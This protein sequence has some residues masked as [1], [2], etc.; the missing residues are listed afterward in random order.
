MARLEW[1]KTSE[2]LY[3][4]GVKNCALYPWD[5]NKN[6]SYSEV[7]LTATTPTSFPTGYYE[8]DATTDPDEF[9]ATEDL[10]YN[11][12][13]AY[14]KF[15][16]EYY[17]EQPTTG[18][19]SR[20]YVEDDGV[21]TQVAAGTE[22][23][24]GNYATI[25]KIDKQLPKWPDGYY[26]N[27]SGDP[28]DSAFSSGSTYYVKVTSGGY[29][30]GVAWNGITAVNETPT[31][32]EATD[33][34][35]D[36]MKYLSLL[37]AEELEGTIEAYMYPDEWEQCDG[38][39]TTQGVTFGQQSRKQFCLAYVT[40]VGNDTDN[41][42]FGEKLHILYNAKA[43]PSE[44]AYA[45]INDS[46]EAITFS[47]SLKATKEKIS[48][49]MKTEFK[50]TFGADLKDV[51]LITISSKTKKGEDTP[52]YEAIYNALYGTDS[53]DPTL[54]TPDQICEIILAQG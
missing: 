42:D 49:A 18:W 23:V 24:A 36:D 31:G 2:R 44:R 3:E 12:G 52:Y 4:T 21:Y 15:T 16:S 28:I 29:G 17:A 22:F 45:T 13:K 5:S 32:A 53:S 25:T 33:L 9:V 30:T 6:V 26:K 27:S 47:W 50:N 10:A 20:F 8:L 40:T 34:Y 38:S 35:A 41:N 51:A 54:L 37:S 14:Y 1:D 43:S 48:D 19:P 39:Y 11:P 7:I 46:P